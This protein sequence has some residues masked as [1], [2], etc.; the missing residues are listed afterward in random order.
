MEIII[1][2]PPTNHTRIPQHD[3]YIASIE[4]TEDGHILLTRMTRHKLPKNK[5]NRTYKLTAHRKR[6]VTQGK[7]PKVKSKH[8]SQSV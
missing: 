4:Q 5:F 8:Q 1:I 2:I 6:K 7:T 3:K